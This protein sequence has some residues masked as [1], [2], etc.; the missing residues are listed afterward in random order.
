MMCCLLLASACVAT[1]PPTGSEVAT[2]FRDGQMLLLLRVATRISTGETVAPFTGSL[3]DDNLG[4]AVG[5]F[6]T[7]GKLSRI[8]EMRFMSEASRADGWLYIFLPAGVQ[9]FAFLPS[10]RTDIFSYTEMFN[11]VQRWRVDAT[12]TAGV[13]YA[14]SLLIE[15]DVAPLLFG[16]EHIDKLGRMEV[17]DETGVAKSLVQKFVPNTHD[18]RTALMQKHKG[19]IILSTPEN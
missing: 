18:V 10:R 19:P 6:G 2:A 17:L 9:Y 15:V 16:Q 13:V 1:Q 5:N 11:H 12:P 4:I 7:G 3:A 14:G 8:E